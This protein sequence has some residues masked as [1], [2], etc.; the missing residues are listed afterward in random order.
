M[1][2]L[3][4][5]VS[6]VVFVSSSAVPISESEFVTQEDLAK[7]SID[8]ILEIFENYMNGTWANKQLVEA[9]TFSIDR[10]CVIKKYKSFELIE[11]L[12]IGG[13]D[14][15]FGNAAS[16][17]K[18]LVL[19]LSAALTCSSKLN[20]VL[21]FVFDNAFSYSS[22]ID[23]FRD[24]EVLESSFDEL[25]CLN[26]YAVGKDYLIPTDYIYL[27]RN[28][29]NITQEKCDETIQKAKSFL[30]SLHIYETSPGVNQ[31][32]LECINNKII[33]FIDRIFFRYVLLIPAGLTDDQKRTEKLNFIKDFRD[34]LENLFMCHTKKPQGEIEKHET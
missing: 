17:S 15:L 11:E 27:T 21:G 30:P 24:D 22:L 6:F 31:S 33:S 3:I 4:I 34:E 18:A 23:V 12:L 8:R 14:D 2:V 13:N 1:K 19:F 32:F 16:N 28:S 9:L 10:D 5:I 29:K 25:T 26:L 7:Q 20:A